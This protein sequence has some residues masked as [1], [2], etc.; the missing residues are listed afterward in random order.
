MKFP[1]DDS[2]LAK[3]IN[4][5]LCPDTL[6]EAIGIKFVEANRDRVIAIMPV[7]PKVFQPHGIVHG[8]ANVALAESLASV[9]AT[10][11]I[12]PESQFIVGLEINANHTRA[13]REGTIT[14]IA[15]PLHRG[16][17]TQVWEIKL[18]DE[19][20]RLLCISRCTLAVIERQ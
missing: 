9:G 16:R 5:N 6:M 7:G 1:E 17:T 12:D 3:W 4:T 13:M 18:W 15:T 10:L 14:G 11:N 8:G 19:Q 2:E 20:Q